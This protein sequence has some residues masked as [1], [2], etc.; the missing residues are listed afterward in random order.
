[1]SR[2]R[3]SSSGGADDCSGCE[4][5]ALGLKNVKRLVL[6]L[7]DFVINWDVDLRWRLRGGLEAAGEDIASRGS[8]FS[9]VGDGRTRMLTGSD[10]P[11][12]Q[13]ASLP[14]LSSILVCPLLSPVNVGTNDHLSLVGDGWGDG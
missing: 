1:M 8:A 13:S 6:V 10:S 14:P 2:V 9:L 11:L 4:G 7:G 3:N 5:G 12:N